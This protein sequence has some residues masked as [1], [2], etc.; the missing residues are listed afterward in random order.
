MKT[1]PDSKS[2][3]I[4]ASP[5]WEGEPAL[6]PDGSRIV[7]TADINGNK[8][9]YLVD[10]RGGQSLRL[11]KHRAED[12]EAAWY[13]DGSSLVFTSNRS[14]VNSLW[15]MGQLGGNATLLMHNGKNP[16]ISPDGRSIAFS[17]MD[18][19][20]YLRVFVASLSDLKNVTKISSDEGGLWDHMYPSWSPDGEWI[21][22]SSYDG[23]WLIP[24]EGGIARPLMKD[25]QMEYKPAWSQ[26][27]EHIYF[28][29]YRE[30]TF[31]LWYVAR[32]GGS[33]RRLT[34]GTGSEGYPSISDDGSSLAYA[35]QIQDYD[36]V[37]LDLE[38]R[39]EVFLPGIG[40]ELMPS[41]SRDMTQLAFVSDRMYSK[42]DLWLI[43]LEN[44]QPA[45]EA[46]R[47]TD[48]EGTVSSPAF[49]PDGKWLAYYHINKGQRDIWISSVES[50]TSQRFTDHD[51]PDTEP[52][53]SPDGKQL[54][55]ASEREGTS[56]IWIAPINDG[57]STALPLR[58]THGE[59]HATAPKCSPDGKLIAFTG[60]DSLGNDVWIV[61]VSGDGDPVRITKGA[62]VQR[63]RWRNSNEIWASGDWGEEK[64]SLRCIT[65]SDHLV[66]SFNPPLDL[67]GQQTFLLFDVASD[68][69]FLAFSKCTLRGDIWIL[70]AING[71]Y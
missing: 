3:Q 7:Y 1:I 70:S 71:K 18:Q 69:S 25:R 32:S 19:D 20:M 10:S 16:A 50:G 26:D 21:C 67:S 45:G 28:T 61:S 40:L 58:I 4:T 62:G 48:L 30:G 54:T 66:Q 63:L 68:G 33:P 46:R 52:D 8:D 41:I 42:K 24:A 64:L 43:N 38:T 55:F 15:K 51:A 6:S 9:I 31:A 13:P 60:T 49:S 14:G 17:R 29:S 5:D 36:I 34:L 22:Y 59:M 23:L 2:L 47:L 35:S 53:W 56:D 12:R 11:T 39:T 37:L 57:K 44:G 27:R 65:L